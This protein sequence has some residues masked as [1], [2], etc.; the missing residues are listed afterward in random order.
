MS[1]TIVINGARSVLSATQLAFGLKLLGNDNKAT[2]YC[3]GVALLRLPWWPE[4][5]ERGN[6]GRDWEQVPRSGRAPLLL[7]S[8][9]RLD[10][11]DAGFTLRTAD[12]RHVADDIAALERIAKSQV[13][14]S[15]ILGKVLRGVFQVTDLSI[16]ELEHGTG[17]RPLVADVSLTLT[18]ASDATVKVGPVPRRKKRKK[19]DS[20]R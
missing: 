2:L 3:P 6:V 18:R 8:G 19:K 1:A 5:L 10:T 7:S 11:Y 9:A 20:K 13:A 4:D 15:L 16:V 14:C 17:G 12:G